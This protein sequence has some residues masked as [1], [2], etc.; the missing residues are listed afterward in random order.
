VAGRSWNKDLNENTKVI[1]MPQQ[2][3]FSSRHH[4]HIEQVMLRRERKYPFLTG[5]DF[6]L[7]AGLLGGVLMV[8]AVIAFW[9]LTHHSAVLSSQASWLA[10]KLL[11]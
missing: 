10:T 4:K 11:S 8:F 7:H 6:T 1:S 5:V 2:P 3:R 9:A